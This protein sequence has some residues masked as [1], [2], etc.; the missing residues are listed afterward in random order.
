MQKI[1]YGILITITVLATVIVIQNMGSVTI[2]IL[3]WDF[4]LPV[5]VFAVLFFL[6]GAAAGFAFA[7]FRK[8]KI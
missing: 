2:D 6:A 4:S 5:I 7:R 1:K 8:R 3:L